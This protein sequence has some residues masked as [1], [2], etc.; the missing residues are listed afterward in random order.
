M[1]LKITTLIENTPGENKALASEHGLSF[2]IEKDG[3]R[4]LFDTGQSGAFLENARQ[5]D[6]D[7]GR[8]D[9]VAISHGHYDHSGGFRALTKITTQFTL[10]T[11]KDFFDE[12]YGVSQSTSK[13]L[14]NNFDPQFLAVKKIRHETVQEQVTQIF[15]G[16][17][18]LTKFPRVHA[19]EVINPRFMLLKD[20]TFHQDMFEDEICLALDTP[21]GLVVVL[22]C[23]HPGMKNILDA[24]QSFLKKPIHAVLGGTHLV[25]AG[26]ENLDLSIQYLANN[27]IKVIGACHCTGETAMDI[28][29]AGNDHFVINRTGSTL[30]VN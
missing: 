14:G 4:V 12:K 28:L 10:Y 17:F 23:S 21:K 27:S 6:I 20:R 30:F 8:L 19:D 2:F 16:I 13:F 7:L 29:S 11:G 24:A 9:A 5:L 25:E 26:K 3:F 1:P 22:G 15:P 18:I